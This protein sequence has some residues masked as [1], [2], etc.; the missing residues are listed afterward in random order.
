MT[1][2]PSGDVFMKMIFLKN[3]WFYI[4]EGLRL[5]IY[6]CVRTPETE[7]AVA[8]IAPEMKGI[9]SARDSWDYAS[10]SALLYEAFVAEKIPKE[11]YRE[12]A[13]G[14]PYIDHGQ[15]DV[16]ISHSG[17]YTCVAVTTDPGLSLGIDIEEVSRVRNRDIVGIS[18][19]FFSEE[20]AAGVNDTYE[21][22]REF[23]RL[24]T[25]K[26]AAMK[27][28]RVPLSDLLNGTPQGRDRKSVV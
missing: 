28:L 9:R 10:A 3:R 11:L 18:Q 15:G 6:A 25:M 27:A 5:R 24:W 12:A 20:E 1:S 22:V 17:A 16:S 8:R 14:R 23:M 26:E 7:E 13:S 19:R 21:G 4:H 2:R